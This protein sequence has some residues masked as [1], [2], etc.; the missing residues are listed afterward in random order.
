MHDD[1]R[2]LDAAV[3]EHDRKIIEEMTAEF[4]SDLVPLEALFS[5]PERLDESWPR[6]R[7]FGRRVL[8]FFTKEEF[9]TVRIRELPDNNLPDTPGEP[10]HG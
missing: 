6:V 4:A 1:E 9:L 10:S 2:K 8:H 7:R 5:K 3:V